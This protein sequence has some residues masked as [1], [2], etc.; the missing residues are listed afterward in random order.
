MNMKPPEKR[1]SRVIQARVTE[2]QFSQVQTAARHLGMTVGEWVR[3]CLAMCLQTDMLEDE[4][5]SEE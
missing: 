4:T 2:S 5:F 1:C 3:A